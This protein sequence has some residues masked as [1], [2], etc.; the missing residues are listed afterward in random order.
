MG[1]IKVVESP[2]EDDEDAVIMK[3]S[4]GLVPEVLGLQAG[5]LEASR[6][7]KQGQ[8]KESSRDEP[9]GIHET[10]AYRRVES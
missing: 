5:I 7:K 3:V 9:E 10:V 2:Q 8:R 1:S 4:K 6:I